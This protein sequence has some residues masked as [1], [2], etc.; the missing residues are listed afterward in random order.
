MD[1]RN[2]VELVSD[3]LIGRRDELA[4]I[5]A[6]LD[7][8]ATDGG[9]RLVWGEPGVGKTVLLGAAAQAADAAGMKVLRASGVEFEADVSYSG[10]NHA[11]L[12]VNADLNALS[13]AYREALTVALGLGTGAPP[14]RLV[15]CNA[16]LALL[17]AV[18]S[19]RPLLLV[20][21][22]LHWL[23]RASAVVLG[24]VARR[25]AGT[26]VGLLAGA[27]SGVETFFERGGVTD[28]ELQ[29]LDE[30]A[31]SDLLDSR[32][33]GLALHV[34]RRL[35]A[36]AQGNPLALLELP[37]ALSNSQL[38]SGRALPRAPAISVYSA[39]QRGKAAW[40]I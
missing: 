21:D 31:S 24:F 11:L 2:G 35:L 40:T 26:H 12:P 6:F 14:E 22:D 15:V 16:A 5:R 20:V 4:R 38:G 3:K 7:V 23:D 9:A 18:A 1:D 36:E 37:M 30:S 19:D 32:F 8:V 17:R 33:P 39:P 13:P 10:L 34:R 25:L 28:Y 29:P 27:R